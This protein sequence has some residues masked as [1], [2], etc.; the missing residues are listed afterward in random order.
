M[1][2]NKEEIKISDLKVGDFAILPM[3]ENVCGL[4]LKV[5][6]SRAIPFGLQFSVK[7]LLFGEK[8][9]VQTLNYE[10]NRLIY[11]LCN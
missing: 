1:M 5:I 6:C 9:M 7:L 4:V 3:Y 10:P 8:T 2:L 11:K